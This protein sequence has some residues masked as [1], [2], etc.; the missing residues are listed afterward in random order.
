M[1]FPVSWLLSNDQDKRDD[2][3]K[4]SFPERWLETS[5]K[6]DKGTPVALLRMPKDLLKLEINQTIQACNVGE[7]IMEYHSA[8]DEP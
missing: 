6:V 3:V 8:N 1:V 4:I 5:P 2:V 7:L